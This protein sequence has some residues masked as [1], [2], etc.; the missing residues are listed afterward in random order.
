MGKDQRKVYHNIPISQN[1][2]I[3]LDYYLQH[4]E[5][6]DFESHTS[7]PPR[8]CPSSHST[9]AFREVYEA[10]H[11]S[12]NHFQ[13]YIKQLSQPLVI[14]ASILGYGFQPMLLSRGSGRFGRRN[15]G[16][17]VICRQPNQHLPEM[18]GTGKGDNLH[19]WTFYKLQL[20]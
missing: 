7:S 16:A 19:Q 14:Y 6:P 10:S 17:R 20:G 4:R 2:K 18:Q 8:I 11:S 9:S 3:D 5:S 12:A 15:R 1:R 13:V